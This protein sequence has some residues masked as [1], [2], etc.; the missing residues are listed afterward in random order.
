MGRNPLDDDTMVAVA[1]LLV[2]L[3]LC[4]ASATGELFL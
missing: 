3:V 1:A 2:V 4:L